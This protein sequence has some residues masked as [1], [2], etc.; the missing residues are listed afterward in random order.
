MVIMNR[1]PI[2]KQIQVVS[3]LV[4]GCSIRATVRMTGV[5]KNTIVKLLAELGDKCSDYLN[6]HV[7][8]L[9]S[10]RIQCDEIWSFIAAKKKNVTS[11]LRERNPHAGDIWT[12]VAMDADSKLIVSWWVGARDFLTAKAFIDDLASRLLNRVQL[13]TDGNRLYFFQIKSAFGNDIDYA[14]LD[15]IYGNPSKEET[16]YSPGECL[17]CEKKA[18]IGDPDPRHISTSYIERQNLTMRMQMR[19]FTRLTNAFS[20]KVE[21]H[22]ASLAI[23]YM[24]YNYVRIHQTLRVT[25]A[26]AARIADRVWGIEDLVALLPHQ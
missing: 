17:G 6:E 2:E 15:K 1:L 26:M 21:N 14:V 11:A 25:P 12:W 19:R 20:K 22:I 8:N 18:K 9:R 10:E 4:E 7:V 24:W 5:A 3:A 16:R 13:T 23:H